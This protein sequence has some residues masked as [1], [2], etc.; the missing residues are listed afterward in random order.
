MRL[1]YRRDETCENTPNSLKMPSVSE[2]GNT[3]SLVCLSVPICIAL[4]LRVS[5]CADV[6]LDG[7]VSR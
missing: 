4:K 6:K 1:F 3:E 7:R 5:G 2:E